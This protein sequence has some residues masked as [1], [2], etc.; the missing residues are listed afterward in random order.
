MKGKSIIDIIHIAISRMVESRMQKP[1]IYLTSE[2]YAEFK[3][4]LVGKYYMSSFPRKRVR[5][6]DITYMGVDILEIKNGISVF[7]YPRIMREGR[8]LQEGEIYNLRT[9]TRII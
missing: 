1:M 3:E 6:N 5:M 8:I 7:T 9:L 4:E 2:D